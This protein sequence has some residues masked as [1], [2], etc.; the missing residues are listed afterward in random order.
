MYIRDNT[1]NRINGYRAIERWLRCIVRV[2]KNDLNCGWINC[3][4]RICTIL[5]IRISIVLQYS[6]SNCSTI[7]NFNKIAGCKRRI[8]DFSDIDRHRC[9]RRWLAVRVRYRVGKLIYRE[10]KPVRPIVV[11]NNISIN[12]TDITML[13]WTTNYSNYG[14]I[15]DGSGIVVSSYVNDHASI[16]RIN[17]HF[18]IA[19][20]WRNHR[21]HRCY[22]HSH[23]RFIGYR[24]IIVFDRITETDCRLGF[25]AISRIVV[26]G[27]VCQHGCLTA[28][29]FRRDYH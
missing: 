3:P 19:K 18:I 22:S 20:H 21:W 17:Y 29:R 12:N 5:V 13:R 11:V 24:T 15:E 4:E 27:S 10:L 28:C 9:R 2:R 1:S 7:F 6:D 8:I 16:T 26:Y 25:N 14:T 23:R